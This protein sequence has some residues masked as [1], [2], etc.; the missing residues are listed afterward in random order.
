MAVKFRTT[1]P[2]EWNVL[3]F[4]ALWGGLA[5]GQTVPRAEVAGLVNLV[6]LAGSGTSYEVGIDNLGIL[7]QLNNRHLA[8]ACSPS[9]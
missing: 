5:E 4:A 1:S 2:D 3:E 8:D 7:A 9:A 6:M